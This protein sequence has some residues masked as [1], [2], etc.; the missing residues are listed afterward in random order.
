[1]LFFACLIL[2]A[3][4]FVARLSEIFIV[5]L[6]D[7]VAPSPSVFPVVSTQDELVHAVIS[8]VVDREWRAIEFWPISEHQTYQ[9]LDYLTEHGIRCTIGAMTV[10]DRRAFYPPTPYY[11]PR[12]DVEIPQYPHADGYQKTFWDVL[13]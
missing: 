12:R 2:P 4:V 10:A 6:N 7:K 8:V 1:M 11:S 9:V 13:L 3:L 5:A